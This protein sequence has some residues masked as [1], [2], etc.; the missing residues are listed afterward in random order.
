MSE[1]ETREFEKRLEGFAP[2]DPP[3]DLRE[4]IFATATAAVSPPRPIRWGWKAAAAFI[5]G[6]SIAI[7]ASLGS[8]TIGESSG[9]SKMQAM[10]TVG[11]SS[12]DVEIS[13]PQRFARLSRL[14]HQRY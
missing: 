4:R 2:I 12:L 11:H 13:Y 10:T 7:N 3:I 5:L 1:D 9:H 8:L 6:G 14:P